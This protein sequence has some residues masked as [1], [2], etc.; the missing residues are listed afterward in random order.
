M[1]GLILVMT[2]RNIMLS[3]ESD[4]TIYPLYDLMSNGNHIDHDVS[5]RIQ[6][7]KITMPLMMMMTVSQ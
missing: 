3:R 5:R 1:L 2:V 4:I 7:E 6:N